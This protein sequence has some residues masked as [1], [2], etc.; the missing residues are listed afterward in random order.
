MERLLLNGVFIQKPLADALRSGE[1]KDKKY[2]ST[3][4]HYI[5]T[6]DVLLNPKNPVN[7]DSKQIDSG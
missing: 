7:P 3:N 2:S 4:D 1:K 5:Q 6:E